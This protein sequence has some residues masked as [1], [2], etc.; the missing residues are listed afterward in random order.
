M[1][2]L[3]RSMMFVPGNN[4]G[5]IRDAHIYGSDCIMFDLEDSVSINEKDA[6]RFLVYKALTS[7]KYGKK[8][9]VVRIND[10]GSGLGVTDLEAMV[11]AQPDVIRLPK[12]ETAQDVTDCETE[13]ARIERE[14][15]LPEG[16]T[17][18]MAAIESAKGVLNAYDIARSSSRLIG[19]ALG[20]E[21]YVTDLRTTRSPEGIELLFA[22]SMIVNAARAAGIAA[23][24][25][26]YSDVNNEEGFIAEATLI[27]K[28][29]FDGKS[30]IN[31]RQIEPLHR[32]FTPTEKDIIKAKAIMEAIAEA[33][34]RGSGVASLNGKMI[35][36]PV[37]E[38]ARYMIERASSLRIPIEEV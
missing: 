13:I 2:R 16:K 4:P 29:G 11:R 1:S 31:P 17:K 8:E 36:K 35:D 33:E 9:L 12:T 21:D 37:V 32:V 25:T 23:L 10:L 14:I 15:G 6:A 5:M 34:L 19:I 26:V 18:M 28:L 7:L 27:K 3:R 30:I 38:R 24:D 22:R 20:A